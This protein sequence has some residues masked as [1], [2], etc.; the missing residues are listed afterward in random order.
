MPPK[1]K[2]QGQPSSSGTLFL[3]DAMSLAFR[4]FFALPVEL[5]TESGVVTNALHGFVSM[6]CTI[7]RDHHPAALAV[8]FD[9]PGDT[10]RHEMVSDYKGGRAEIP[11]ELPP[12]FDMIRELLE[13][14]HIPVV[15]SP[16]YEADDILATLATQAKER[17]QDVVVVTGDRDSFQ[18]VEDPHVQVL[19][20]KRGVSD[21]VLY[22][23]AGIAERTGVTPK[24]YPSLAAL[25][26]DPSD[27]LAGVPGVGEKTAAKLLNT[28]GSIDAIYE[29]LDELTPKLRE[30]LAAYRDNVS[31][32]AAVTM[33]VRDV[34]LGVTTDHL[35]LGGWDLSS[36]RAVFDRYE[37]RNLWRR[38]QGLMEEGFFGVPASGG[39]PSDELDDDSTQKSKGSKVEK[40]AKEKGTTRWNDLVY[41]SPSTL[42]EAKKVLTALAKGRKSG[43]ELSIAARF[44]GEA[45]RSAINSLSLLLCSE[46]AHLV[47]LPGALVGDEALRDLLNELLSHDVIG[48]GVKEIERS[49]LGV[50][51]D[52]TTLRC[53]TE[54]AAY[55]LDP[56]AGE[57]PLSSLG[58]VGTPSDALSF[59]LG[60]KGSGGSDEDAKVCATASTE[61]LARLKSDELVSLFHDVECPL[62]GVLARMEARGI[63]VDR[64]ELQRLSDQLTADAESAMLSVHELAGHPFNVNSTPQLRTVLYEEL[65]LTPGRKTKTG[66]STDAA[67]LESLRDAH[68]IVN[69][70]LQYREVEKLRSTYGENLLAEVGPDGRIHAT[71]RQ[72]V[73]RTGRL[74]SEHPNL[75]NIPTRSE[76]GNAFRRVFVPKDGWLFLVADYD[77]IEL[78][79]IAHLSGD[80]GLLNAFASETDIHR[81][82][83]AGVYGVTPEK[84]TH[85]Q[86]ERAKMVSYGLAYGMEA[87]GLSR[88]LA[89]GVDE[90]NEIMERYFSAFPSVHDYMERTV[91]EARKRGF[92]RTEL[93]RIRPL[94]DLSHPN[95]RVRQ[96]AERQA[97]NA[98]IQGLAA[99]LFK[100]ALVRL[101]KDL[102]SANRSA[103]LVLQVHDEVIVEFPP[104]EETD[105]KRIVKTALTSAYPLS[106]PLTVSMATGESWAAA[107]GG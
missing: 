65:G 69:A 77:Q 44:E 52:I 98:G 100:I 25:R 24:L 81:A 76:A 91:A 7:V 3:L 61:L 50:G 6:L 48:H 64:A 18:L 16:G 26:G 11:P 59:D 30:N 47:T 38:T 17:G 12:Q 105:V 58:S 94:P 42:D 28:Y 101:D 99:D 85:E 2:E 51:V 21:Y 40:A 14:L 49:L 23:E 22:D 71:F 32:N 1:K 43:C 70:L 89:I 35:E 5:A 90:A 13:A 10:F 15:S 27:N 67:T 45:G 36:A 95:Y 41:E 31:A 57:Y 34:A 78:R 73:A 80:P 79:V 19:Y 63:G 87:Y 82:V 86:R 83:A 46:P 106:V 54:I 72:T 96:A 97:M 104:S 9:L 53:D 75:H 68:P 93:G 107:K 88:R 29:H 62:V 60:D 102:T 103:S 66:F 74:S 84:V 55:L 4:A 56:A 39:S 8:A 37:L 92:T 33:L 20:N